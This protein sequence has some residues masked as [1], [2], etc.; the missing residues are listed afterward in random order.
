[1]DDE[2][3]R[4]V[5]DGSED[6]T[7]DERLRGLLAQVR[8]DAAGGSDAQVEKLLDTRL[9]DVGISL[10]AE[11]RRRVLDELRTTGTDEQT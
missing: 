11:H 5:L 9:T 8:N 2:L 3:N 7:D 1:M 10:S 6:A 4:P